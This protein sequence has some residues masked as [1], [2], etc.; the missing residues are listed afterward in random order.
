M[1]TRVDRVQVVVADR[2]TAAAHFFRLL[3]AELTHEDRLRALGARRSVVRLGTS[4][5]E[6]LEPDG[7]GAADECLRRAGG[8]LFAAGLAT[9]DIDALRARLLASGVAVVE[10]GGQLLLP[11]PSP[12]LR[13]VVTADTVHASVGCVRALYEVTYLVPDFAATTARIG[14][15]FGLTD[16]HFVPIRS[17]E[18]GYQG[19]LT[20]FHPDRLDRIEV[21]TPDDTAKTMGR[22]FTKRGPCL[23]MC[24]AEADDLCAIRARLMEHA[25]AD[26]TGARDTPHVD[27]LFIHP[28]A[29]GGM[30]MGISRTSYAWTW[31]GHP[32]RV[33]AAEAGGF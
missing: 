19:M 22:F 15:L 3:G 21:V 26:W 1:L 12:G 16:R 29:L 25:P 30:M 9:H 31:S 5:V 18:F 17:A 13:A 32:E 23:Y 27:N 4:A 7:A 6:L 11:E 2:R 8:G 24:Y 10:E 20:L 14:T 33:R 28:K